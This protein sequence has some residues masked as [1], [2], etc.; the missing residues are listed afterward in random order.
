MAKFLSTTNIAGAI[1]D[2]IRTA[3]RRVV[4]VSPYVKTWR[5]IHERLGDAEA[6]GVRTLLVC[7]DGEEA[8]LTSDLLAIP[9]LSVRVL[10]KL[11]AKVYSNGASI[12][13]GSMNL[14]DFSQ[15]QGREVGILLERSNDG[16]LFEEV[17]AEVE[18]ILRASVDANLPRNWV[19]SRFRAAAVAGGVCIRCARDIPFSISRPLCEGCYYVWSE[20]GNTDYPEN[21]CHRCGR[22]DEIS[23]ARPLCRDCYHRR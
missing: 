2:V 19:S 18:S 8:K 1:D 22:P 6:R 3:K 14:T 11:H 4:L 12:V 23:Y 9:G 7:R 15:Q 16:S 13:L 5:R 10:E 20:W 17:E 21:L